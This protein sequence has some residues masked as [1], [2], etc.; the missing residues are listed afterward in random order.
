[1]HM[2]Q[3]RSLVRNIPWQREWLTTP[4]FLPGKYHG[5]GNL[6]GYS[7]WGHKE[8]GT[9]ERQTLSLHFTSHYIPNSSL[10]Y[11]RNFIHLT[12]FIQFSLSSLPISGDHKYNLFSYEFVCLLLMYN[13][14]PVLCY[15]LVHYIIPYL[16][17]LQY[18]HHDKSICHNIHFIPMTHLSC[19]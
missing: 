2:E 6:V 10:S 7:P 16:C 18:N 12:P 8:S 5:Q 4:V 19:N 15:C 1:M 9:T 13:W 3:V 11:N 14:P 17:I